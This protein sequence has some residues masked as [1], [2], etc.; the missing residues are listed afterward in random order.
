MTCRRKVYFK[1]TLP[2]KITGRVCRLHPE[3]KSLLQLEVQA[4]VLPPIMTKVSSWQVARWHQ[5]GRR[6]L[7]VMSGLLHDKVAK[8]KM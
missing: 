8:S 2:N 5:R 4:E 7:P 6:G 1:T 3:V